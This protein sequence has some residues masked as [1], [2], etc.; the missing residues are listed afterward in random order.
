VQL[1]LLSVEMK[2]IITGITKQWI[3]A[4]GSHFLICVKALELKPFTFS[5]IEKNRC[6]F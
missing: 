5:F 1:K 2:V 6:P 3:H 4:S